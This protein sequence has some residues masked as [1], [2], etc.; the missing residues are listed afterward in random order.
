MS[1]NVTLTIQDLLY[2]NPLYKYICRNDNNMNVL[3]IGWNQC[4]EKFTD[5][6]LQIGQMSKYGLNV[7]VYCS[8]ADGVKSA[9]LK[10]RKTLARFVDVEDDNQAEADYAKLRF[11]EFDV[12][13]AD[14]GKLCESAR[15]VFIDLDDQFENSKVGNCIKSS[16]Q[17]N[18]TENEYCVNI[19]GNGEDGTL[20]FD[21][22]KSIND[23]SPELERMAFNTHISWAPSIDGNLKKLHEEFSSNALYYSSSI[24]FALSIGY[25]LAD[26]DVD[27]SEDNLRNIATEVHK[28]LSDQNNSETISQLTELEHRRWCIEK[29]TEGWNCPSLATTEEVEAFVKGCV[30]R[31][32]IKDN[33]N[34]LH[35]CIIKNEELD[36]M[37][38]RLHE[39]MDK[40][41]KSKS[42]N[43]VLEMMLFKRDEF[44]QV[45]VAG[46]KAITAFKEYEQC[47]KY[48]LDGN[49]AL[50]AKYDKYH[51]DLKEKVLARKD[52]LDCGGILSELEEVKKTLFPMIEAN[53]NRDYRKYDEV[54]VKKIPFILT[55][56]MNIRLVMAF[57]HTNSLNMVNDIII[58]NVAS[59]TVIKPEQIIYVVYVDRTFRTDIFNEMAGAISHY[60]EEKGIL[61]KIRYEIFYAADYSEKLKKLS[62]RALGNYGLHEIA[63]PDKLGTAIVNSV[64]RD[65]YCTYLF[66]GS[67]FMSD[68]SLTVEQYTRVV[69]EAFSYFEFDS[70]KKSF[71]NCIGCEYLTYIEDD[72]YIG[73][74]EMFQLFGSSD[75]KFN[76]PYV[77]VDYDYLWDAGSGKRTLSGPPI[78]YREAIYTYNTMCDAFD[79]YFKDHTGAGLTVDFDDYA[80][81]IRNSQQKNKVEN[82]IKVLARNQ[83][84]TVKNM[85]KKSDGHVDTFEFANENVKD[86]LR[87]AGEM[88][89]VHCYYEILKSGYFDE[90]ATGYEFHWEDEKVKSELDLVLTK[91]FT[92]IFVECKATIR[93]TQEY[94]LKLNSLVD[95]FGINA[96]KVILTTAYTDEPESPTNQVSSFDGYNRADNA[97]QKKRGMLMDVETINSSTDL[98]DVAEAFKKLI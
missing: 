23:S 81:Y 87:K 57:R 58:G 18:C 89:E 67:S 50:T 68:S 6:C 11:H 49:K 2:H 85:V 26:L 47:V 5:L 52:H 36:D 14:F 20:S 27:F 40:E 9:Y 61:T 71:E 83:N 28:K 22:I 66:D 30:A 3:V 96:K 37:S 44:K 34:K 69:K 13:T 97:T 7:D 82:L 74:D 93:L 12:T 19:A 54:L 91:G 80:K 46:M 76:Y 43:S 42:A 41:A 73:I 39:A 33:E 4:C 70:R 29:I 95:M 25:K 56:N 31:Q 64:G 60:F 77:D 90:V 32:S 92:S 65:S 1:D 51:N 98:M 24:S 63:S 10:T 86:V 35:P 62:N 78:P 17:K 15:Y 45:G 38:R 94:Y 21:R 59:A 88:F 72:S 48:I 16:L 84:K 8:G 55:Y 53:M 79:D 75:V